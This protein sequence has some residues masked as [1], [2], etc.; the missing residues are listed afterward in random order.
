MADNIDASA[1]VLLT[2]LLC[3]CLFRSFESFFPRTFY[4]TSH[5]Q[6]AR[7][8]LNAWNT[9]FIKTPNQI[10]FSVFGFNFHLKT[11]LFISVY[12][13]IC[14]HTVSYSYLFRLFIRNRF[15]LKTQLF[16]SVFKK[17]RVHTVSY[18]YRFRVELEV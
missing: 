9:C 16:N 6:S 15:H 11:Q 10:Y 17:V 8:H 4:Y 3:R 2:L 7:Q 14:V 12:K 18:S 13:K 5:V 1:F